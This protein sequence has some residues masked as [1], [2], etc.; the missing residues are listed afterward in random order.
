MEEKNAVKEFIGSVIKGFCTPTKLLYPKVEIEDIG[1]GVWGVLCV[2]AYK[3]I[4]GEIPAQFNVGWGPEPM[5]SITV[6]GSLPPLERDACYYFECQVVKDEKYGIAFQLLLMNKQ[7][8]LTGEEERKQFLES[9]LTEHQIE[10]L[11]GNLGN[12]FETIDNADVYT[13][14]TINGIGPVTAQ[15][16]IE[17]YN[18]NKKDINAFLVLREEY[19]LTDNAVIKLQQKYHSTDTI[20]AKLRENP[21]ELMELDGYGFKKCDSLALNGGMNKLSPFRIAA[22]VKFY[23]TEQAENLGNTWLYLKDLLKATIDFFP[24]LQKEEFADLLKRWTGR[25]GTAFPWLYYE[26]E[27]K[28]IGLTY[29]RKLEENIATEL[30]RILNARKI[31]FSKSFVSIDDII[32]K[33]ETENGWEYT[34]E[35]KKAI[36]GCLE[37]NISIVTGPGGT[38]KSSIMKPI[39]R[40]CKANL[41]QIS[42]TALSGRA[43]SNLSEVTEIEG[44]TIH[45]LLEYIPEIGFTRT[46]E[47]QLCEDIVIV[48]EVS[49]NDNALFY[50]LLQAIP[51]GCKVIMLGDIAQLE[52]IGCGNLLRDCLATDI[53]PSYKLTKIQRQAQK[54]AIITESIKVSK[55]EQIIGKEP[56]VETRGELQD[57]K[58]VTYKTPEE[59]RNKFITEYKTLLSKGISPKDI[60]GVVPMKSRGNLSCFVLNNEIQ[61]IVNGNTKLPYITIPLDKNNSYI[62]R[63]GDRVINRKNHYDTVT[64]TEYKS[65]KKNQKTEPIFNGNLGVVTQINDR[66]IVVNFKQQGEIVIKKEY[67]VDIMLGYVVTTHSFQ[68]SQ[69]PYVIVGLD[70]SSYTLLSKEMLYTQISRAKKYCVLVGQIQ[71]IKQAIMTSRI[72]KKQT[73]LKELLESYE[74]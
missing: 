58:I 64:L 12:P 42:Q 36:R 26:E 61:K 55:G 51:D 62:V 14:S 20:I 24:D 43:A 13:L 1:A 17:K 11:Y 38:G 40:F 49:M 41:L 2:D 48:D 56:I 63:L 67:W 59:S 5:Y 25:D 35:Q 52:S 28:R 8:H 21:Y 15:K 27:S 18:T 54:S 65:S 72:V 74:V 7:V 10:L 33:C 53:I 50:S 45:R 30:F 31:S 22:F 29:Y 16:I 44:M 4:E 32:K 34:E 47:Q 68:G 71:A 57:L 69:S 19:G 46:K 9:I 60:V 73:W 3:I 6:K 66:N 70:M 39:V 23:L 37:N